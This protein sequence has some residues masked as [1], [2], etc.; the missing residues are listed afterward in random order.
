MSSL[1]SEIIA[2]KETSFNNL[3]TK[4]ALWD[5]VEQLFH[6]QLNDQNSLK[7]N[8]RVFDPK[9]ATLALER[10]YRVMSQL[11]TGKVVGISKNDL[12]D[13]KL[14]SLLMDKYVLKNANAQFDF[15]TKMRMV[16]LYSGI[17]GNFFTLT[18]WDVKPNGYIG[19]DVWLLNIRDVFPQVGAVSLED[20]DEI[21]IRTWRPLSFFEGLKKQNGYKNIPAIIAK[22]KDTAGSKQKRD[23]DS[24]SKREED[25]YSDSQT[26]KNG[27]Y[28]ECLTR[29]EK[30]RWVDVCVDADMEFRD[31]KNPHDNGELPVDCKYSIPL[32]DD[33]MGFGDFERGGSMQ[34][35]I[36]SNWNLY[37]QAVK[38]SI[39][40]PIA[41]DKNNIA[42]ASS[43][44]YSAA[45][46]WLFKGN[47]G[48]SMT[49]IN[50]SPQGIQTFNNVHQVANSS[51]LNLFGTTDTTVTSQTDP[52]MGKTPDAIKFQSARENTRDNADRFF[53]EQY[54][55]KVMK[56]MVNLLNKKQNG[57]LEIRM[58]KEEIDDLAREYPEIRDQYDETT[59][60]LSVKKTP[61]NMLYDY[62]IV[63]GST[64]AV[65]QKSQQE[66]LSMLLDLYNKSQTPQGNMLV[67]D[68]DKAG[69]KF[70]F[71][72]LFKKLVAMGGIQDWDKILEE[73][74]EDEKN[75]TQLDQNQQ[76]LQQAMQQ[77]MAGVQGG[78]NAVPP[79]PSQS[80]PPELQGGQIQ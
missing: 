36:N 68:L 61:G 12:G 47:P 33:F 30:D 66:N 70:N 51:I 40:P 8:S 67:A 19:P 53:M 54:M 18:D 46:K 20:S 39:F 15:L 2:D 77:A 72:E 55:G 3:S 22:L 62:E 27:G 24:K 58:F 44:K 14:K 59:G 17:Y 76:V 32:L 64:Y 50:L 29:Y 35:F 9:L 57:K 21:I 74:T 6:G 23:S 79:T 28:Y 71:G 42:S 63:S 41:I 56:K 11:P 13:A 38:M 48:A 1:S 43:M 4:R 75:Q 73:K 31:Q 45:A 49:P 26:T 16:D 60:K 52:G 78:M 37:G 80:L 25:Q 10:S 65:D 7:S 34:M 69:Y 5:K